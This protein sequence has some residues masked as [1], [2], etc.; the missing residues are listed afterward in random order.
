MNQVYLGC[1]REATVELQ[2]VQPKTEVFK[3]IT[4]TRKADET[5]QTKEKSSCEEITAWTYDL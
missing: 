4:T 3:K 1:T 5:G 2:V